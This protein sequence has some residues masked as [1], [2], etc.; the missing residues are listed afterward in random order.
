MSQQKTV[1][2][3]KESKA[4]ED[5]V[6]LLPAEIR[7]FAQAGFTPLV[8]AAA[9]AGVGIEDR[10]YAEVG[11]QIV[12]REEAWHES[13]FV[14]KYKAPQPEEYHYLRDGLHL[15]A[16]FH[17]EGDKELTE[18]LC[19]SGVSAFSYEFFETPEGIFPLSFPGAEVSGKLAI[20]Y[21]AY[22][23]QS[24][25]GGQGLLLSDVVGARNPRVLVIGYGKAGGAAAR[26]AAALGAEVSVLGTNAERLRA[27]QATVPRGVNCYLN[28]TETLER[29]ILEADVVVGAI[30]ISSYDTEPM[31]TED[32]VK[33]MKPGSI[34]IDV[35]CGYGRGYMPSFNQHSG[36]EQPTYERFGVLHCKFGV[37]PATVP[38]TITQAVSHQL[39]PYLIRLGNALYEGV[40]DSISH[41]GRIVHNGAIDHPEVQRQ[42]DLIT[43]VG[44]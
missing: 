11:A 20:I 36:P 19:S 3:V 35:T 30:L 9:G 13:G 38:L 12:S 24:Q 7:S 32:L 8:E 21:A 33:K 4:G 29:E 31:V 6:V 42:M 41:A 14:L 10:E 37:M 22:H 18:E 26:M 17:A 2:L 1:S 40:E 34:I 27:F 39:T 25:F 28:S 15:G 43:A 23:L 16:F 44:A 5:R